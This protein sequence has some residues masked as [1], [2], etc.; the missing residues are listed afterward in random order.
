MDRFAFVLKG[1]LSKGSIGLHLLSFAPIC[2]EGFTGRY[3][4]GSKGP[5]SY[6]DPNTTPGEPETRTP[7]LAAMTGWMEAPV[8]TI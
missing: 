6:F 7:R 5:R 4:K 8:R 1:C 3:V 2:M